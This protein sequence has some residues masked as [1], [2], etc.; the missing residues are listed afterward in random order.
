M[1][2]R[3]VIQRYH[4]NYAPPYLGFNA[5]EHARVSFSAFQASGQLPQ[6]LFSPTSLRP[7]DGPSVPTQPPHLLTPQRRGMSPT[8][9]FSRT[10]VN[11]HTPHT[12]VRAA[13][14]VQSPVTPQTPIRP[15]LMRGDLGSTSNSPLRDLLSPI[16]TRGD[17]APASVLNPVFY[18]V[19]EGDAPG[20][21]GSQWASL[22]GM[23]LSLLTY[24]VLG[25]L[26]YVQGVYV[27]LG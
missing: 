16:P 2:C 25:M 8:S 23:V 11:L 1:S 22:S 21:Y 12:P 3:A 13:P 5:E 9:P 10:S 7:L 18:L 4:A 27:H 14:Q 26:L 20:V 24:W 6:G 17:I 15:T 19:L